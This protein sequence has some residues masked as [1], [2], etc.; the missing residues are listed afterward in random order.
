VG[1]QAG[2]GW[3]DCWRGSHSHA[4]LRLSRTGFWPRVGSGVTPERDSGRNRSGRH[5]VSLPAGGRGMKAGVDIE[6]VLEAWSL[7]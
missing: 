4:W 1:T 6:R 7:V 5:G 3:Q 2:I